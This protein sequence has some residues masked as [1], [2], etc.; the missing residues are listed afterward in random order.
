M[1][2]RTHATGVLKL[3]SVYGKPTTK[4]SR[5]LCTKCYQYLEEKITTH[6][7]QT[8]LPSGHYEDLEDAEKSTTI[9]ILPCKCKGSKSKQD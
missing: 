8:V 9:E 6:A 5:Q 1:F 7:H 3:K 2:Q 4:R